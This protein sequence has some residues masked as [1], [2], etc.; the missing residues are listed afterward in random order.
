MMYSIIEFWKGGFVILSTDI[1]ENLRAV[2]KDKGFIQAVI[3]RKANITPCKLSQVLKKERKLDANE[4]FDICMAIDM[5]PTELSEYRSV[6][7]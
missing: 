6:R 5:T 4:L 3:A 2:I 1:R 7:T